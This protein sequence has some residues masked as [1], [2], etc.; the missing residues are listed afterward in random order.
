MNLEAFQDRLKALEEVL[1]KEILRVTNLAAESPDPR[2][3]DNYY[4]LA[5]DL[6]REARDLRR[7]IAEMS[8]STAEQQSSSN[9]ARSMPLATQAPFPKFI[10]SL[11]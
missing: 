9:A 3:Q 10:A 11:S 8:D 5:Q 6:Q 7:R 4:R 1:E 2:Q